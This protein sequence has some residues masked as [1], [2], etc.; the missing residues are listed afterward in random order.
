MVSETEKWGGGGVKK[1]PLEP[2]FDHPDHSRLESPITSIVA[3]QGCPASPRCHAHGETHIS[4]SWLLALLCSPV[5][6]SETVQPGCTDMAPGLCL[7]GI[8]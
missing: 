5:L 6:L 3:V 7:E 1:I 4:R 8:L 2:K